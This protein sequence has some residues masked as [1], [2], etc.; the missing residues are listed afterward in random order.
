MGEITVSGSAPES[1][2]AAHQVRFFVI[3]DGTDT[4]EP[5]CEVRG[6]RGMMEGAAALVMVYYAVVCLLG[7]LRV[8]LPTSAA[9]VL[10]GGVP[11]KA[12]SVA[13]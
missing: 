11:E 12:R 13:V 9:V 6:G 7:F 3:Y 10:P 1:V 4:P 8:E 2:P 5:A